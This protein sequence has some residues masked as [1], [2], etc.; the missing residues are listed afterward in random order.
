MRKTINPEAS[1][2][3]HLDPD[4]LAAFAER[5]L[6]KRD[7]QV[8]FAHL[9]ECQ[10]CRDWFGVC[11]E[12]GGEC[13]NATKAPARGLGPFAP[14]AFYLR[15]AAGIVFAILI[16]EAFSWIA[17]HERKNSTIA[18]ESVIHSSGEMGSRSVSSSANRPDP[19]P[20][21]SR[22]HRHPAPGLL[23]KAATNSVR[24]RP[25]ADSAPSSLR[26]VKFC[27]CASDFAMPPKR[28]RSTLPPSMAAARLESR[29]SF[30]SMPAEAQQ[31]F[32]ERER[33]LP[34]YER[35]PIQTALGVRL[36][37]LSLVHE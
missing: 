31:R 18:V 27:L 34:P 23:S 24:Q 1:Q 15:T 13:Q 19:A 16:G 11:A 12:L 9:A 26:P 37:S 4:T 17:L 5:A 7:L 33:Q 32:G 3:G 6:S 25:P 10:C 21:V 20:V 22:D 35:V 30:L 36:M 28:Q 29:I 8:T 14:G 2:N